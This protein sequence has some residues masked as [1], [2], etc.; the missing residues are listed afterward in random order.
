V[1]LGGSD[2]FV[3]AGEWPMA[4]RANA[5]FGSCGIVMR[6]DGV[7]ALGPGRDLRPYCRTEDPMMLTSWPNTR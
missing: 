7:H 4:I 6:E 2:D 5:R 1:A 3:S